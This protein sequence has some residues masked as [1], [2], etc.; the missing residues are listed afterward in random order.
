MASLF[1]SS[2]NIIENDTRSAGTDDRIAL[3][4]IWNEHQLERCMRWLLDKKLERVALQLPDAALCHSVR[5]VND[6]QTLS[7]GTVLLFVLG[8][9]SYGSCCVDEIAASHAN[10]DGIIHFGH[11]CLSKAV[12]IPTLYVFYQRPVSGERLL[13][14]LQA[15]FENQHA[16]FTCF[17]DVSYQHAVI[18]LKQRIVDHFPNATVGTLA[19]SH[20]KPDVLCWKL[21]GAHTTACPAVY[22]GHDNLSFFNTCV[23]IAASQW[24][25]FDASATEPVLRQVQNAE[26]AWLR[27]RSYAVERCKDAT[28]LGI[29]VGTLSIA[30]YLDV[31]QRLQRLAKARGVRTYI[32][33][34]GKVN[35]AKLANFAD[36]DC[37]VLVGCPENDTF[38]SRDFY[39]PLL[40]VY[41]AEIA[42]NTAWQ[43][44]ASV[45]YTTNFSD[46]LPNGRLH[47]AEG[48]LSQEP[49]VSLITGK[50]RNVLRKEDAPS[51][52]GS[53]SLEVVL[54]GKN[55]VAHVSSADVFAG[56]SWQGL[57]QRLGQDAPA[58]IEAGRSGLPIKYHDVS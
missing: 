12:R 16:R 58:L 50:I 52:D 31:V 30:G 32:I 4:D 1:S 51:T 26:G 19:E 18:G 47:R 57:E 10:A 9:T 45:K 7:N 42:L 55:E 25:L 35:V 53:T 41:E 14:E 43:S 37:F 21:P 46:L 33:S 39:R 24:Y 48:P 11:A 49:D 23:A 44:P 29:V 17:Y 40:S 38:A 3:E 28:T 54:K 8:D 20:E 27:R 5:I 36:L 2:D 15:V 13:L 56:H 6:L 22:V 34:V